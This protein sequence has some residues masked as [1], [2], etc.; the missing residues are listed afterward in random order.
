MVSNPAWYAVMALPY[1][2]EFPHEC[3]EQ[4]FNRLYANALARHIAQSDPKIRRVFDQWKGTPALDSPLEKNQDLKAV[5]L[6]ET[7]WVRQAQAESQARRNVGVLF[8]DNRLNDETAAACCASW[9]SS[10]LPTAPGRG[11]PAARPTTTSPSTSPP[12]SAA[13]GTWAWTIDVACA[14][15]SLDRLDGW[16]DQHLP[17]DPQARPQGREPPEHHDRPVPVRPQLLPEGPAASPASTRRRST[18][19]WARRDSTGCKLACRQS[20]AHLAI[21]L[22]RFGDARDGAGHPAV[23]QGTLGDQRGTGHVL[24]RHWSCPGGGTARRSRPRR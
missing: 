10:S 16:I 21:A 5:M 23:D 3:T 20:Q 6:E 17:R 12:A 8:D 15:K 4:T 13:C 11:S 7:P 1:L 9:P 14:V 24:A 22:K 2:M 19:S 18:T